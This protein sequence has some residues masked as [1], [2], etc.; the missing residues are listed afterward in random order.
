[1]D[2][3]EKML[4]VEEALAKDDLTPQI[5]EMLEKVHKQEV[6]IRRNKKEDFVRVWNN[7]KKSERQKI[8][9]EAEK[10]NFLLFIKVIENPKSKVHRLVY[11]DKKS[12]CNV[13]FDSL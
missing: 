13:I 7:Y 8:F 1:M 6:L 4:T 3:A 10:E 11:P 12:Y 5:R 2:S 9:E